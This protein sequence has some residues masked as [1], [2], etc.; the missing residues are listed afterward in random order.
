MSFV[1]GEHSSIY[2]YAR[3]VCIYAHCLKMIL[4]E[5][6]VGYQIVV[7]KKGD[8]FPPEFAAVNPESKLPFFKER[9]L[10]LSDVIVIMEY[11]NER[12]P[13]PP[14]MPI[15]PANRALYRSALIQ[16][17]DSF[18]KVFTRTQ[19]V[20][21]K[22]VQNARK[23]LRNN[24]LEYSNMFHAKHYFMSDELGLL[25]CM[26][27]P[28]LW[29]LKSIDVNITHKAVVQYSKRLFKHSSFRLSMSEDEAD[30]DIE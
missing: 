15:E 10:C 9:K 8:K 29:R 11:L 1:I 24:I 21:K 26:L 5:K 12:F 16:V 27:A 17:Y 23:E 14:L 25:D 22:V 19:S 28:L 4:V 30:L 20:N 18:Y 6:E 13:H 3:P 2:L 7:I